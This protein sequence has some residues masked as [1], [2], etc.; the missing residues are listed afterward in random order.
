[1]FLEGALNPSLTM[2]QKG[3]MLTACA[4]RFAQM[5]QHR[6]EIAQILCDLS[7][8]VSSLPSSDGELA[9][10]MGLNP[11]D[12]QKF[13]ICWPGFKTVCL[14]TAGAMQDNEKQTPSAEEVKPVRR[15]R[16]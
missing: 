12:Y 3:Q 11:A 6:P 7:I 10:Y 14:D 9:E 2:E 8:D 1:M 13:R 16:Y 4:A 5:F 15:G